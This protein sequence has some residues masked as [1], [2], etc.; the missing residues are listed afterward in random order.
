MLYSKKEVKA[1]TALNKFDSDTTFEYSYVTNEDL[2]ITANIYFT[3]K[4][5][6]MLFRHFDFVK[7]FCEYDGIYILCYCLLLLKNRLLEEKTEIVFEHRRKVSLIEDNQLF[8][9]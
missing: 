7:T 4:E 3:I 9:K 6:T 8:G 1:K 5:K 2:P